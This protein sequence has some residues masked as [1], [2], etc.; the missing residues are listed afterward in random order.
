M[1]LGYCPN[2]RAEFEIKETEDKTYT[3]D[4]K[5]CGQRFSWRLLEGTFKK[6]KP[7]RVA[8]IEIKHKRQGEVKTYD[9]N[10]IPIIG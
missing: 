9:K 2:C 5:Q 4:C 6:W 3:E 1:N 8:G 10:G 7:P